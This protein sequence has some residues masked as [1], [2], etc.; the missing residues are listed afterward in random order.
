MSARDAMC[1]SG[2][3]NPYQHN[4]D[5]IYPREANNPSVRVILSRISTDAWNCVSSD[6]PLT[7]SSILPRPT[8]LTATPHDQPRCIADLLP[9]RVSLSSW[10]IQTNTRSLLIW[11]AWISESQPQSVYAKYCE[12]GLPCTGCRGFG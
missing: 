9:K 7:V 8:D 5:E 2:C 12:L 3:T 1:H 4:A 11:H 10:P 6:A